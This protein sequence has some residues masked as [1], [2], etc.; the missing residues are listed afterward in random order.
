MRDI[1]YNSRIE[2]EKRSVSL[3]N[4]LKNG[5]LYDSKPYSD[6]IKLMNIIKEDYYNTIRGFN[7][8]LS[9]KEY[10]S[11]KDKIIK[12][13]GVTPI[14]EYRD[15]PFDNSNRNKWIA[16]HPSCVSYQDW[17]KWSYY[18]CGKLN[19]DFKI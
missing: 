3:I 12:I 18:L 8:C 5:E 7:K 10:N 1:I 17:E 4:S 15:N 13:T 14:Y 9:E 11:I 16:K 19:I 2:L 6:L